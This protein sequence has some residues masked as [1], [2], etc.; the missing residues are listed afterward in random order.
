LGESFQYDEAAAFAPHIAISRFVEGFAPP[1]GGHHPG[2]RK[3]NRQFGG[4]DHVDAASQSHLAFTA[5]NA[6]DSI[7]HRN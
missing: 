5:A 1:V 7:V 2:L 6:L 3:R 4:E